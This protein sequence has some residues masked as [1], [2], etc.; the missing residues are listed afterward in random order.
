M[1]GIVDK[2]QKMW[3][4]PM[5]KWTMS[6][7]RTGRW[8]KK[9]QRQTAGKKFL[10]AVAARTATKWSISTLLHSCKWCCLSLKTL[11]RKPALWLTSF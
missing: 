10:P 7:T 2:F 9:Q 1:A 3:N 8:R 11:A 5:T 4:P 6:M